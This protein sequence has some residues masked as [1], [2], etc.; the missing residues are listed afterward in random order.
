MWALF[1]VRVADAQY[2]PQMPQ[3]KCMVCADSDCHWAS[4]APNMSK[5]NTTDADV[6]QSICTADAAC[7]G[8]AMEYQGSNYGQGD[9]Y[10]IKFMEGPLMV[11]ANAWYATHCP[12]CVCYIKKQEQAAST[13]VPTNATNSVDG[14]AFSRHYGILLNTGSIHE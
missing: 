6:C 8:Y 3:G 10:C 12:D 11:V 13:T 5:Q 14:D 1:L 7:W 4:F 2:T 9:K